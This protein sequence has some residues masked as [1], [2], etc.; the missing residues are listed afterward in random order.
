MCSESIDYEDFFQVFHKTLR[1][2]E[3][4]CKYSRY[5]MPWN[6]HKICRINCILRQPFEKKS[7]CGIYS[8]NI[9]RNTNAIEV[10]H[11]L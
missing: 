1:F 11:N 9:N 6:G 10:T 5:Q 2:D 8:L 4:S 7:W 3:V